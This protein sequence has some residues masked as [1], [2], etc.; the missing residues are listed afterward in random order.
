MKLLTTLGRLLAVLFWLA[1]L[2]NLIAPFAAPFALLLNLAGAGVLLLHVLQLGLC[3]GQ[4]KASPRATR[5]SLLLLLFGAFYLESLPSAEAVVA[6]LLQ[7][8][9][10]PVATQTEIPLAAA[11]TPA[12]ECDAA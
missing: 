7:A 3:Q 4:I 10:E 6:E 9:R 2:G 8:T 5:D 12:A 1:V 11:R